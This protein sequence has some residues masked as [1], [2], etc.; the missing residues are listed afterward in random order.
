MLT[1]EVCTAWSDDFFVF[2]S[3]GTTVWLCPEFTFS[4]RPIARGDLK[5]WWAI[6]RH[7]TGRPSGEWGKIDN[8]MAVREFIIFCVITNH[9]GSPIT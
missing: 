7:F 1:N 9:S 4:G 2:A 8:I 6:G 5:F 3:N